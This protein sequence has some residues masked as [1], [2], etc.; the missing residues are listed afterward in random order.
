VAIG[1]GGA[2]VGVG[3]GVGDGS[4]VPVGAGSSVAVGSV[5]SVGTIVAVG[6]S[7]TRWVAVGAGVEVGSAPHAAMDRSMDSRTKMVRDLNF[8]VSPCELALC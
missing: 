5:V 8:I 6:S 4:G 3:S 7:A 2:S 1:A